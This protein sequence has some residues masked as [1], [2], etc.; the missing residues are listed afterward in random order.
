MIAKVIGEYAKTKIKSCVNL[1]TKKDA[2][3]LHSLTPPFEATPDG[4]WLNL[5]IN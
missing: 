3:E 5:K 4:E 1:A 2:E